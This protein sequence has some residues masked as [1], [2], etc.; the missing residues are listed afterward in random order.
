MNI[1]VRAKMDANENLL[2]QNKNH[3]C[4]KA[5]YSAENYSELQIIKKPNYEIL[6]NTNTKN[7]KVLII[8]NPINQKQCH[9]FRWRILKKSFYCVKCRVK[10][11]VNNASKENEY[12]EMFQLNHDCEYRQYDREKY[13]KFNKF[14]LAPDFELRTEMKRGK[15]RKNLI[16]LDKNDKTKCYVF[17]FRKSKKLFQC[18]NCLKQYVFNTAKMVQNSEGENYVI[19]SNVEH[20]CEPVKYIPYKNESFIL[21]S[22]DFKIME[23]TSNGIPKVFIFDPKNKNLC[24]TF[25]LVTSDLNRKRY[26]CL[27]CQFLAQ[28]LSKKSIKSNR[29]VYIYLCKKEN[30]ENF[31]QTKNN[32]KHLCKPRKYEPEK[33]ESKESFKTDKFFYYRKKAKPDSINIAIF[34]SNDATLCYPFSYSKASNSIYCLSCKVLKKTFVI[35][36]PKTN[37]NGKEYFVHDSKKHICKPKKVSTFQTSEFQKLERNEIAFKEKWKPKIN[38]EKIVKLPNFDFRPN[39]S[40]NP[41]GKLVVSDVKDKSMFYEFYFA[42]EKKMFICSKCQVKK[43]RVTAKVHTNDKNGEKFIE[44]SKNEHICEPIKD[45]YKDKII[46][47][48]NFIVLD[49]DDETK[50]TRIHLYTSETKEFY[51][52][53]RYVVA[54]NIFQCNSCTRKHKFVAVKLLTKE[55]GE[56]YLL[57]MKNEHICTPK[58]YDE[59]PKIIPASMFELYKNIKREPNKKLV[60]F[61]SEKKDFIYEYY[62]LKNSFYCLK[63]SN[64]KPTAKLLGEENEKYVELSK[65][66]HV[67]Q[68]MKYNPKRYRK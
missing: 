13:F 26:I 9:E 28:K 1:S 39:K 56:E 68:P 43:H 44:L 16:I 53:L 24:Y 67:C 63:C 33:Y 6:E 35:P 62:W 55:S 34:D 22:P 19:L 12:I 20:V 15:E 61:T 32:Q 60:I 57:K 42:T 2:L 47:A 37:E 51:Y 8:F 58:K 66:E 41:E 27:G 7:G 54:Q 45:E 48:S 59:P 11:K 50:N 21:H 14:I 23:K 38:E 52:E 64:Q 36:I 4:L 25:S 49:R 5:W 29:Y 65:T 30:G 17:N 10:A 31:V 40:G 18:L 46:E 3:V